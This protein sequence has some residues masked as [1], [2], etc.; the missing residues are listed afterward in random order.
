MGILDKKIVA[1][2]KKNKK[3]RSFHS[4][5]FYSMPIFFFPLLDGV[6]QWINQSTPSP[7]TAL[8]PPSSSQVT[9][10]HSM[11]QRKAYDGHS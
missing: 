10:C 5:K 11:I 1:K 7:T 4:K 9:S 8:T 6:D 2:K 3:L